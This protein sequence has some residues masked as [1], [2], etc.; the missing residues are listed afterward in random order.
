MGNGIPAKLPAPE[1]AFE[2]ADD[3]IQRLEAA[4]LEQQKK[5]LNEQM[6]EG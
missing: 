1:S 2:A 6:L 5:V 4:M 3:I